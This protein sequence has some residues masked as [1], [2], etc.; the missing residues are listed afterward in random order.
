[1]LT[2]SSVEE[3]ESPLPALLLLVVLPLSLLPFPV[4]AVVVVP[5]LPVLLEEPESPAVLVEVSAADELVLAL[6]VSAELEVESAALELL[7]VLAV[8]VEAAADALVSVWQSNV[9]RIEQRS[10]R[11]I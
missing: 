11:A 1:L 2:T 5:V 4:F 10:F 9:S 7:A 6:P 8:E 3:V